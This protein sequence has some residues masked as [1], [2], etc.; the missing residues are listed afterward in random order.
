MPELW[1]AAMNCTV[2]KLSASHLCLSGYL[3]VCLWFVVACVFLCFGFS[4]Q[5]I[6]Y[7]A[8]TS[9]ASV[10]IWGK[11]ALVVCTSGSR[12][13]LIPK[14]V[15]VALLELRLLELLFRPQH[16]RQIFFKQIISA[17]NEK[18]GSHRSTAPTKPV[19]RVLSW[20]QCLVNTS[21]VL[22]KWLQGEPR[23]ATQEIYLAW[24][25]FRILYH[26]LLE[27]DLKQLLP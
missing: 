22:L 6:Q 5:P 21:L 9:S 7:I 4:P 16:R 19:G 10:W 25:T 12:T 15:C 14:C 3:S 2:I 20:P 24:Q 26:L 23:I 8:F 1:D 11:N 13:V 18:P 27:T 17:M